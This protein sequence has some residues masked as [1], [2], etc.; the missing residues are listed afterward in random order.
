MTPQISKAMEQ[1][2]GLV[3]APYLSTLLCAGHNQ[4]AYQKARGARDAL[5]FMVLTWITSFNNKRKH[6]WINEK[7]LW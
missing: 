6:G 3:I 4:F 1:S 7:L 5:A 2:L